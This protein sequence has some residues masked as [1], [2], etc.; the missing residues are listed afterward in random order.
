MEDTHS[1]ALVGLQVD[2][3]DTQLRVQGGAFVFR[4]ADASPVSRLVSP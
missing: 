4:V 1:Y 3:T 2:K